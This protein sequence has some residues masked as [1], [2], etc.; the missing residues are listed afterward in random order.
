MSIKFNKSRINES[1]KRKEHLIK[2]EQ[3]IK[4]KFHSIKI[5]ASN[6]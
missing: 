4:R 2:S 3:N 6:K 1:I 5:S